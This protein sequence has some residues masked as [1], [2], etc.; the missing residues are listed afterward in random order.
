MKPFEKREL[1]E[2]LDRYVR[3][4]NLVSGDHA[5]RQGDVDRALAVLADAARASVSRSVTE[6]V[7]L[8]ALG[9]DEASSTEIADRAGVSRA[10]AQRHLSALATRGQ[11]EVR[12]RY[13]STGRPEHLYA[14]V[15]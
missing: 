1:V 9:D 3:F 14:A 13:G 8:D 5:L 7:V 10:T 12:L 2:R 6:Q 4:R 11:V 15:R